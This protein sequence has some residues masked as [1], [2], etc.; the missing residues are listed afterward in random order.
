MNLSELIERHGTADAWITY[1]QIC[2]VNWGH[3]C[4]AASTVALHGAQLFKFQ[5]KYMFNGKMSNGTFPNK[6]PLLLLL[7]LVVGVES[8]S[9]YSIQRRKHRF[10]TLITGAKLWKSIH[11][12]S[13]FFYILYYY[14]RKRQWLLL[15]GM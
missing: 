13:H 7:F 9:S 10:K 2:A 3:P 4:L 11:S 14:K 1:F 6:H 15:V 5:M 8:S 12:L